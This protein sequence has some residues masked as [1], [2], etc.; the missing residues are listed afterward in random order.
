MGEEGE[1]QRQGQRQACGHVRLI[2]DTNQEARVGIKREES[3]E[4]ARERRDNENNDV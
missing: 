4:R 3:V 2:I 1:E